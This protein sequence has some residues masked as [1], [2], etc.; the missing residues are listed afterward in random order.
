MIRAASG[1]RADVGDRRHEDQDLIGAADAEHAALEGE[2]AA[3]N[4]PQAGGVAHAC[5]ALPTVRQLSR[6]QQTVSA[7]A[8]SAEVF[9]A[10]EGDI[11][12]NRAGAVRGEAHHGHL[13][14]CADEDLAGESHAVEFEADPR[15]GIGEV[16]FA[17]IPLRRFRRRPGGT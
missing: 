15:G 11:A 16:E 5:S 4:C 1:E 12:R 3:R 13:V 8:G 9:R 2:L 7:R 14:R 6:H 10:V 17:A